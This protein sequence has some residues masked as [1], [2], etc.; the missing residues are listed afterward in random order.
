MAKASDLVAGRVRELRASKGWSQEKLAEAAGLSKDAVS[1]IERGDR[2]PRLDTLEQIAKAVGTT[3]AKLVD[4]G[5]PTP[6][7]SLQDERLRSLERSLEQVDPWLAQSLIRAIQIVV[8][9]G[10]RAHDQ[11]QRTRKRRPKKAKKSSKG[12]HPAPLSRRRPS[13]EPRHA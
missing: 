13:S 3:L 4:F 11:H 1:R 5:E 8:Q 12:A 6:R 7:P 9:A 2:G 10:V